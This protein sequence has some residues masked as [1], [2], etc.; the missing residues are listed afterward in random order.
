M[1]KLEPVYWL[2]PAWVG[3]TLFAFIV[4]HP[5]VTSYVLISSGWAISEKLCFVIQAILTAWRHLSDPGAL[6]LAIWPIAFALGAVGWS[7]RRT[8]RPRQYLVISM[9]G[10]MIAAATVY[11]WPAVAAVWLSIV[12]ALGPL[13][14]EKVSLDEK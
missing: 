6:A 7:Q 14:P 11:G 2:V 8:R 5:A 9:V 12:A 10:L 4:L 13:L 3:L 1:R